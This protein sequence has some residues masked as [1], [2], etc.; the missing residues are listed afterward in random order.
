MKPT[1]DERQRTVL[2]LES[3]WRLWRKT[4]IGGA[5]IDTVAKFVTDLTIR[6]SGGCGSVRIRIDAGLAAACARELAV[7]PGSVRG[8]SWPAR[9]VLTQTMVALLD[10]PA[11]GADVV[12]SA[13]FATVLQSAIIPLV[14]G[15]ECAQWPALDRLDAAIS[16]VRLGYVSADHGFSTLLPA[17]DIAVICVED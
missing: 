14:C 13:N 17:E 12:F 10:V 4:V 8:F 15:P 3:S 5:S 1:L 9:R 16:A 7:V 11:G 2:A 6:L